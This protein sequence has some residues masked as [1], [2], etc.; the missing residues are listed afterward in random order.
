MDQD[1]KEKSGPD[2]MFVEWMKAASDFWL[3]AAKAAPFGGFKVPEKV[4]TSVAGFP[5]RMEEGWQALLKIWQTSAAAL[6]SPQ[7]LES[8]LKGVTA[9]PEAAMRMARTTWDGY[10]QL[11]QMWLKQT[12]KF[13][14]VGK[15]YNF[16]ALQPDTFKEWT[17]FYEKQIQP[18]LKMPQVGLTRFYQERAYDAVD[19]FARY[20]TAIAEFL[21]VLNAPVEKSLGAMEKQLA[22]LA[23]E[24]KLPENFKDYYNM[25]I[26][27]L[28]GHYMTLYKSPEYVECLGRTLN[29]VMEYKVAREKVLIDLLQ[30]LPIPT[31]RDMDAL[32][33]E[34]YELKKK[35]NA[36]AKKL[37]Q[38]ASLT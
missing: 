18:M 8:V 6:S 3:S 22:E 20:Q 26:K 9:S 21:S 7:T 12:G 32:Y 25:W 16:E 15:A 11:Y 13:G 5:G 1:N 23:K 14:E 2:A 33:K 10:S 36:M 38:P 29:A 19:K 28:E 17:A 4:P 35:V 24:G 27:T 30:V 37:E 31:N 34:F